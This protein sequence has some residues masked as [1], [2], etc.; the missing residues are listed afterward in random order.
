MNKR[1]SDLNLFFST[2]V[3][4]SKIPNFEKI[5]IVILK[6]LKNLENSDPAGIQKSNLK[7][8]HSQDFNMKDSEPINFFNAIS[9]K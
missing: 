3:W 8:W 7:G 2:P 9:I 1:L 6:Y 5:N 4:T